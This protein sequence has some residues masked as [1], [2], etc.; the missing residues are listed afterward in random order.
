MLLNFIKALVTM[1][2][3]DRPLANSVKPITDFEKWAR[4]HQMIYVPYNKSC[5]VWHLTEISLKIK[6]K[7]SSFWL[8]F[9]RFTDF[10]IM[11]NEFKQGML[12]DK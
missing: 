2:L 3:Y 6:N 9:L 4:M 11:Q 1:A 8:F 12:A 7:P 5:D 10:F